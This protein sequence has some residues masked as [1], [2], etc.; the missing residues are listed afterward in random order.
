[1][2]DSDRE[3]LYELS[4]PRPS[5]L[6]ENLASRFSIEQWPTLLAA[7]LGKR[8]PVAGR[9]QCGRKLFS[10]PARIAIAHTAKIEHRLGRVAYSWESLSMS[11]CTL[12]GFRPQWAECCGGCWHVRH[13]PP[14]HTGMLSAF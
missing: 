9:K 13:N 6:A 5:C 14:S 12:R 10:S 3:L 7:T 8:H 11:A 2:K 4:K 1:M